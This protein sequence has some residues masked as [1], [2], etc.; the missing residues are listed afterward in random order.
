[1]KVHNSVQPPSLKVTTVMVPRLCGHFMPPYCRSSTIRRQSSIATRHQRSGMS[2]KH[3]DRAEEFIPGACCCYYQLIFE[4]QEKTA[5]VPGVNF[6]RGASYY[7]LVAGEVKGGL[8]SARI[9]VCCAGA[10]RQKRWTRPITSEIASALASPDRPLFSGVPCTWIKN[11]TLLGSIYER[12]A[13]FA[14]DATT[15]TYKVV[16][17]WVFPDKVHGWKVMKTAV[18]IYSLG[19]GKW[20]RINDVPAALHYR[21]NCSQVLLIGALHWDIHPVD[22]HD[23]FDGYIGAIDI[24]T[25]NFVA[26]KEPFITVDDLE[27]SNDV[28]VGILGGCLIQP[29]FTY[30]C[31]IG[32]VAGTDSEIH[33]LG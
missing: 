19:S 8:P 20:R 6:V 28:A 5:S 14:Y 33:S 3:A 17:T 22:D 2:A 4:E 1:M 26:I 30:N 25:E 27:L 32:G 31:W 15:N 9:V 7:G 24:A 29:H 10:G 12:P 23:T 16:Y 13:G 11:I 21:T 18:H